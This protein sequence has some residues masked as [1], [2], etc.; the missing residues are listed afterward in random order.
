MR[1]LCQKFTNDQKFI[2]KVE[3]KMERIPRNKKRHAL[4]LLMLFINQNHDPR[5]VIEYSKEELNV[6]MLR[7][8]NGVK[9]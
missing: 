2:D 4:N 7:S 5:T 8:W 9:Q 6:D 1:K 3:T